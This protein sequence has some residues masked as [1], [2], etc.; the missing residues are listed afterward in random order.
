MTERV[1]AMPVKSFLENMGLVQYLDMFL[2]KGYDNET[3]VTSLDEKDLDAMLISDPDH[4]HQI[5]QAAAQYRSP[6]SF[7][8]L[9]WLQRN[10]LEHY[11]VSFVQSEIT[12]MNDVRN[13][14]V[15][16]DM[17]DEL[18]ITLPGHKKR[19]KRA[20]AQ[21]KK[22]QDGHSPTEDILACGRWKKPATLSDAKF[23]FLVV[24][25]CIYSTKES[26]KFHRIEFMVDTGSDVTTIRQEVLD[27]LDLEILGRIHS[28]GV[29]GSKTTNLYKAKILIGN[30]EMEIEVMGESYDSLGSRVV[31]HF[32]HYIDGKHHVWLRG[33]FCD[34]DSKLCQ[35]AKY[36]ALNDSQSVSCEILNSAIAAK[37]SSPNIQNN[38][39]SDD[40][41]LCNSTSNKRKRTSEE[42]A[43]DGIPSKMSS[44]TYLHISPDELDL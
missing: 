26:D 27:E 25:A 35:T 15:N 36:Q 37:P 10:G 34:E 13:M 9:A 17:F 8:V 11:Y 24:D 31:R 32:R 1:Q 41:V 30:Q 6:G 22:E 14:N 23:D 28:K 21:L 33:N 43:E 40:P 3:D 38:N 16:E 12:S 20:V 39:A 2:I 7:R 19:L 29:H 42:S 44:A 18:E 4:R 5:L